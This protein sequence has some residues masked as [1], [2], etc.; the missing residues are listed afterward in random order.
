MSKTCLFVNRKGMKVADVGLREL[1]GWL[2]NGKAEILD[3]TGVPLVD[4]ALVSMMKALKSGEAAQAK[5][6]A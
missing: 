6:E 3:Q 5:P 4:R 1:A 2:R